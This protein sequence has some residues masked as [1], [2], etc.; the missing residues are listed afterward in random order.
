MADGPQHPCI[1]RLFDQ[2]RVAGLRRDP[3][4]GSRDLCH[5]RVVCQ[6]PGRGRG[7]LYLNQQPTSFALP[8]EAVDRLRAAR[9]PSS[10]RQQIHRL[11]ND[12]GAALLVKPAAAW[13]PDACRQLNYPAFRIRRFRP[14]CGR[15]AGDVSPA[16]FPDGASSPPTLRSKPSCPKRNRQTLPPASEIRGACCCSSV[17][18]K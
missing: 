9:E 8:P 5:R 15:S 14:L 17:T 6:A 2:Q 12:V 3:S 11:L 18:F 4:A 7:R 13:Q 1:G 16:R 10:K